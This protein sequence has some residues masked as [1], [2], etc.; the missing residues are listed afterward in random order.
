MAA[1]VAF[2]RARPRR[3]RQRHGETAR[4]SAT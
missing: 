4:A 2:P 1:G 3:R